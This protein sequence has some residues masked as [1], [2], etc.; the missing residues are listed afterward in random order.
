MVKLS[1]IHEFFSTVITEIKT[2]GKADLEAFATD[3]RNTFQ[4]EKNTI[5]TQ[6]ANS[7]PD[8]QAAVKQTLAMLEQ[9]L[10]AAIAARG[11]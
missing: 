6:I 8:V 2:D 11:L 5:L 9:A 10:E 1:E 4:S 3:A 7:A